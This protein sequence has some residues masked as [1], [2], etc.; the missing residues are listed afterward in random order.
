MIWIREKSKPKV[1]RDRLFSL[2]SEEVGYLAED[3]HFTVMSFFFLYLHE[4]GNHRLLS[5]LIIVQPPWLRIHILPSRK[6][7][8][9]FSSAVL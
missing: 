3:S 9:R 2:V 5:F 8:E 6:T 4:E 7:G 1:G